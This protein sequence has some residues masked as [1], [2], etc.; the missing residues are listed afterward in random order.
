[1]K[2]GTQFWPLRRLGKTLSRKALFAGWQLDKIKARWM[3]HCLIAHLGWCWGPKS[4]IQAQ[5][6]AGQVWASSFKDS[7]EWP[8]VYSTADVW[9]G[10]E[11]TLSLLCAW[12]GSDES[13][14]SATDPHHWQHGP[15]AQAVAGDC[16][17]PRA[18]TCAKWWVC[19]NRVS[20]GQCCSCAWRHCHCVRWDTVYEKHQ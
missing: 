10:D 20:L 17:F 9:R 14:R 8:S 15:L 13:P 12:S 5:A 2:K 18:I 1:M 4:P 16:A 11:R 19:S 3:G 7:R 6:M